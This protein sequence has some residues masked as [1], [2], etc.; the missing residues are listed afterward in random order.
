MTETKRNHGW[1]CVT[2]PSKE[3]PEV[4]EAS[5]SD[6]NTSPFDWNTL[7]VLSSCVYC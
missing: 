5:H 1:A 4:S 3:H 2:E 7:T 6:V